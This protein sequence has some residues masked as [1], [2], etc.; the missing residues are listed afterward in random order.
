MG[1]RK[2]AAI[3]VVAVI[4]S[5]IG[6][7]AAASR[8][9]SPAEIAA[10]TA[11]PEPSPILVPAE[12]RTISSDVV[13]RGTARFGS[14]QNLTTVPSALKAAPAVVTQLPAIGTQMTE[15]DTLLTATG[16]PVFLIAGERLG[17]RDLGPGLEGEDVR[18][19]EDALVRLGFAPGPVDG[20]Y[21]AA[22]E[23]AVAAWYRAAGFSPFEASEDQKTSIRARETE[24]AKARVELST[25]YDSAATVEADLAS[26][27]AAY[28]DA[29][30]AQAASPSAVAAA[31][32]E[33]AANDETA[34]ADVTAKNA[35]LTDLL[36]NPEATPTAIAVA[37]AELVAAEASAVST[38]SAGDR[39]VAEALAAAAT[40]D[41]AVLST[42]AGIGAAEQ[43]L[44]IASST[45]QDQ[46]A[47]T[48]LTALEAGL[49][50]RRAGVQVPA[51]ELIFASST[52]VRV[53]ELLVAPGDQLGGPVVTVTDAVVAVDGALPLADASLV[54]PGMPVQIDEPD[55]GV[56]AMGTIS[57]VAA[58]PG[59]NGVDGF[60]IWFEVIVDGAP[61]NLVGTSLRLTVPVASTSGDVLAV[62]T[63]AV[64]LAADGSSRV[65]R[66]DGSGSTSSVH[67]E[68][69]LS[70]DGFVQVTPVSGTLKAGDLVVVGASQPKDGTGGTTTTAAR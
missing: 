37:R 1:R 36:A 42:Q 46:G 67:V 20:V 64:S 53:S 15:G 68:P 2:V 10:Q 4:V 57:Q 32:A 19:L 16:R 25:A 7:W 40:A 11:P 61:A 31:Q 59:T 45:V 38:R 9:R 63:S 47:F 22:T 6:G 44:A 69:G 14:P 30:V 21:D 55:L 8:I 52:P 50:R 54:K 27:N 62:P 41:N 56:A 5:S 17:V 49:E 65:E 3:V 58:T 18:Q 23:S 60:H 29:L 70:A 66:D 24:L 43:R 51:D 28:A 35:A 34:R 48:D 26:A 33:A 13:T 12:Q 39:L